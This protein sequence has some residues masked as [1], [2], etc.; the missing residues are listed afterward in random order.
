ML[1]LLIRNGYQIR[2]VEH[3]SDPARKRIHFIKRFPLNA[4]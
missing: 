3:F 1:S 2:V 4:S